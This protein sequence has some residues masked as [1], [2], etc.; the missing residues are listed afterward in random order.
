MNDIVAGLA[1]DLAT[2][3][4]FLTRL[5]SGDAS[6]RVGPL[7]RVVW[8]FPVVGAAL[9]VGA[10][11]IL[12][13]ALWVGLP[14]LVAALLAVGALALATGA[15]HEDGLADMADGLGP[16]DRARA[17]AV[18]REGPVGAWGVL[19]LIFSVGL[20][21]AALADLATLDPLL[22]G[23]ALVAAS[24]ASRALLA[25][26]MAL[27]PPARAEGLG[28]TAGAP[29]SAAAWR[30]V[31]IGAGL[32]ALF[33]IGHIGL[34]VVVVLALAA[35]VAALVL[36]QAERRFGGQTGDVLGAAQQAAEPAALRAPA[37][38][39]AWGIA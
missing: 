33:L 2:A 6:D 28:A 9:G 14:V 15:L 10:A 19:A 21:V 36:R 38:I 13:L 11:A 31:G 25:P 35:A 8:A 23:A 20:R 39:A 17:L 24:A 16:S 29:G 22:A 27:V 1:R 34:G 12:G 26:A 30:T 5:P 4:A 32:A 18:M 3:L 37:A 7:A